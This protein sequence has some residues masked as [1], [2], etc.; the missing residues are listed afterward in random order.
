MTTNIHLGK[1]IA[2]LGFMLI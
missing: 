1:D 2:I